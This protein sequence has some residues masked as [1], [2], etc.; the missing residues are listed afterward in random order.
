MQTEPIAIV[1]QAC[2]LP[3]AL[4]PA[5]LWA[6]LIAG[7]SCLSQVPPDRWGLA[8]SSAMG[9]VEDAADRTWSDIGGYV[10]GFKAV[11]D[12]TGFLLS[13]DEIRELDPLFQW[14]LHGAREALRAI[15]APAPQT[16]LVLGG[17]SFPTSAMARYAESVWLEAQGADFAGGRA[18]ERAGIHRP[19]AR[20]R[21]SSG[22]PAH[23]AARALGLGAG[24]FTV[25]AACASSL[26]AIKLACDQLND[27]RAD[28]MVAG[29]VSRTDDLFTHVGFTALGALS[30]TGRSRPF[31]R[32]A[33]GLVPAE[34]AGFVVLQRLRD[35]IQER[36]KILGVIRAVG[37]SNDGRGR[38]LLAP[39][40]EGQERAMRSAYVQAGIQPQE[41][42]LIEC[43]ATGTP[44]GDATEIRST[45][46]VFESCGDV[47]IGSLKSN[48]GHLVAAAGIAGLLKV[49]AS[50]E[51]GKR[52]P[53]LYADP[54]I[55]A[56][57]STPFRI[58]R[59][60]EEWTGPK[61]AAVSAFGFG[62][63]NAHLIVEAFD[64]PSSL[65]SVA[66][67]PHQR[68][69]VAI[70]AA[71]ARVADGESVH[72]FASALFKGTLHK[73]ARAS[74]SVALNGLKFPP[75]DL[76]QAL[77]QQTLILEAAREAAASI[78]LPRERTAV[79]V[80]MGCDPE[81]ARYGARWKVVEWAREW[82]SETGDWID[83]AW[84]NQARDAFQDKLE[85]AGA[86]GAMPNIPANR[87]NGQLDVA[88]PSFT[89]AAE[90]ASGIVALELAARALREHE[91]DAAVVGAVDLSHEL[92]HRTALAALGNTKPLGDAA[93]VLVLKRLTDARRDNDCVY[94]VLSEDGP[95]AL[96]LGDT[97]TE[98]VDLDEVF[99]HAHA[100]SGL[101]HVA[102]GALA[103][104]HRSLLRTGAP[105][106]PWVGPLGV[107]ISVGVLEAGE[108]T[109]RL[110]AD[111]EV[112]VENEPESQASLPPARSSEQCLTLAAHL[113][114]PRLPQ[115][116]T[117]VQVMARAPVLPS[118][119]ESRSSGAQ[120][121]P[122][123]AAE[124]TLNSTITNDVLARFAAYQEQLGT[125]HRAFL[126]QH[127][128]IHQRFLN[129]RRTAEARLLHAYVQSSTFRLPDK[130]KLE[131][132]TEEETFHTCSLGANGDS[133]SR[134][135]P[136]EKAEPVNGKHALP[137]P[138]FDRAQLEVLAG[139]SISSV[140]GELFKAQDSYFRQVRMPEPPLLLADRVTGID[141]TPGSMETGT[142]W[143]ETN[144]ALDSWYLDS[145]GRMPAGIMIEAGQAD[146]LLISWLGVDLLNRGERVYRL[147][148]CE[149]TFKGGLPVPGDTLAFRIQI[150]GHAQQGDVRLFFFHYD[151][152][153]NGELRLTVRN[154]QAGFFS[155]KELLESAGVL[156][157]C[158]EASAPVNRPVDPP[159][160]VCQSQSF[161]R[162]QLSAFAE[163]RPFDCFGRGW[164]RTQAH[165]RTARITPGRML[166]LEKVTEFNP[167]RGPWGRGY[168]RAEAAVT[169]DDWFFEGHFKNDPC[170]PGTLMFEACLQAMAFYL[171]A[172]GF[173]INHD[174]WAFE[175][176]P[177]EPYEMR[178]RGQV[179][180]SSK[181]LTYEV[182]VSEVSAGPL[183]T[184]FADL[185]CT[186]D[187]L[188]V[189]HARRVGVRL[190]PAW[191]LDHWH[192]LQPHT[193]Q[194][195]GE[196][197]ALNTLGGL[198]GYEDAKPPAA[199]NGF[200]F[201]YA[202]LLACA[203]GRPSSAFGPGYAS[204]NGPRIVPRLPGPPYHFISRVTRIDAQMGGMK[205]GGVVEVEYDLPDTAWYF[206]QNGSA[207]MP[208]C[209]LLEAALQPCGWL[210]LYAGDTLET[211]GDLLFRNL[212]GTCTL[213][214]ELNP[215]AGTLRTQVKLLSLVRT[216]EMTIESFEVNCYLGDRHILEM[217]A[218]FGIFPPAAFENQVGLPATD[219]E[220]ARLNA[221][222]DRVIDLSE[223]PSRYFS[224]ELRL[225]G[226]MLLMIDRITGFWP[227]GG[228]AGLG[229]L[230]AEKDVKPGDWFFKAHFFQDPVQPGSLGIDAMCQLLQFYMIENDLGAAVAQP[231]FEPIMTG[232]PVTWTFRGQV[233]P[234]N[235]LVTIEMEI[236]EVGEDARG[237]F[238]IAEAWLWVDG[239][240]I[241]HAEK[242][243]MR[244]VSEATRS[245]PQ[246]K[247]GASL[248]IRNE[249]LDPARDAWL[250][251][252]CP[253]WTL[254]VLPM[255]SIVDRIAA[256]AAAHAQREVVTIEEVQLN[257]WLPFYGGPVSLRTE[258]TGGGDTRS[259]TLLA[260]RDAAD[261]SLS[262]FEQVAKGLVH[263]GPRPEQRSAFAPLS[264]LSAVPD[265]YACGAMFHGPAFQYLTQLWRGSTGASAILQA[266]R[267]G[268]P[269]G[270]LHQ[271]LLDAATHA[272][273]H[274]SLW[275]WSSEIPHDLAAYPHRIQNMVLYKSL[276]DSG[277]VRVEVRFAGVDDER[278]FPLFDIQLISGNQ[279]CISFRLVGVLLP[280]GRI[281]IAPADARRAFLRD[282]QYV[283]AV[284][285]SHFAGSTTRLTAGTVQQSDWLPGNIATIYSV[286]SARRK[287]L[288][289]EEVAV[290][291][292]VS[293]R[294][295][296]HP[297]N[298]TPAADLCSATTAQH[299]LRLYRLRVAREG[300][301]VVVTDDGLPV[302]DLAPIREY[303]RDRI[304][305]GP[306]LMEDL[307]YGLI[308][309][310][311]R[312]VVVKD[313]EAFEKVRG[314]SCLYLANHQVGIESL[315]FSVV[316]S[317]LSGVPAVTLAKAEHKSSWLGTLIAHTFE[318]PGVKN[319][320]LILF[321]QR[322]DR[323]SLTAILDQIAT[324]MRSERKSAMVHVE[325]TRSLTCRRPVEKM[326]S[327]FIDMALA[328]N[329]PIVPVRFVGGLPA[330]ELPA[331]LS[332]PVGF[333]QQ[334]YWL[335]RP[336]YPE[337]LA[338]MPYKDRKVAV[339][340][341][342][343]NL[344]PDH[345][346]EL[347]A[348]PDHA[349]ESLIESWTTRTGA[350]LEDAVFFNT[351]ATLI[352]KSEETRILCDA[353]RDGQWRLAGDP[354]SQ[355][356]A[357]LAKRFLND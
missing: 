165:V 141:A 350:L 115:F 186:V 246:M 268:V 318:H 22:L 324:Q 258:V 306:W 153:V 139:G 110:I 114:P 278:R 142:I 303:W 103:L 198:I 101:V 245:E 42:G 78:D 229:Y 214:T 96:V 43:H 339:V 119:L 244:I 195:T 11:F 270:Y 230:R 59:E 352:E 203:W 287:L 284:A 176:V 311:V 342:I 107:R 130:L 333:G 208:F 40:E 188:K 294:A 138:K 83:P 261:P 302:Q 304:G 21:F 12:P 134:V 227:T 133:A 48:L 223:S 199:V 357:K 285:L 62:G 280:K 319:L 66:A 152:H 117:A 147:L 154:A 351:L 228:R 271:G 269:R 267:G 112:A 316:V 63:N 338:R 281:G 236:K 58:L 104:R 183:P 211:T 91:I 233:V 169:P 145:A 148:G 273:P 330:E 80:G 336:I 170:M 123:A 296:V 206:E 50:I 143:T 238:V 36:R 23:L 205:S 266:E 212:D 277:D 187:G 144:V 29:A 64:G 292:H 93:V 90:E 146:L 100:A 132:K 135:V 307:Y 46:R 184:V 275:Q 210:A 263:F 253:T 27:G 74:V 196:P 242:L 234:A 35:A 252:H 276:P 136:I 355:W 220:R 241:Y 98:S 356:L 1:G 3:G 60:A 191:P 262:R 204:L 69:A 157:D 87:I 44:V 89:V 209:V 86:L 67:K 194:L 174:G 173:T 235:R 140:F 301:E 150:D 172:M 197:V 315:L 4:T 162:A 193:I 328:V 57:R 127:A 52:P 335:G 125:I 240:R 317:A 151:C 45:A 99:G 180:P 347:P 167:G 182:F 217:K 224:G 55:E 137:G 334:D 10:N 14:V 39:S 122:I 54:S 155:D 164:E 181:Q 218:V 24:A 72:D 300:D 111:P 354:Q 325:G 201:G 88:G 158:A 95:A 156:W 298:V 33:D 239:M 18:A 343:N 70:V 290:R 255:M 2:T 106:I 38:G 185:L 161:S 178:C 179:T 15:D 28:V 265:L 243:G 31:H 189:F 346:T 254:P 121:V 30:R 216:H 13:A 215:G 327:A 7:R 61:R 68:T 159:A 32:D 259:V 309:R 168:L 116:E 76:S 331:R 251:D 322:E 160:V 65:P 118:A 321:F 16:G 47:P 313:P 314:R 81:L 200:K 250:A 5:E 129:L 340:S 149:L 274:D 310:F 332:F 288:L 126:A 345:T 237:P 297:S 82:S 26:Y 124:V 177:D 329:A 323:E 49:L 202:S 102:A 9:T 353:V 260:W 166:L 213:H 232:G 289:V 222:S 19:H 94:G 248:R 341:A 71:G 337:E 295:L 85:A 105:A 283:P 225:P 293:R 84:L 75:H 348:P 17:L 326:S 247:S 51:N 92:V 41:I 286:P 77:A 128:E 231:R 291:E 171:A 190:A 120:S 131:V 349:F 97:E 207:T 249:I 344:G 299:P 257:R 192:L 279:I 256:A 73:A 320:D 264:D 163:G 37:L 113:P 6:N 305:I 109:L 175:P 282:R 219:D 20:N 272:I 56:L 8:R 312:D 308:A 53:T 34:G 25:D 79:I 221:S 108:R 226:P